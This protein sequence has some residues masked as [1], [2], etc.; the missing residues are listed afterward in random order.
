MPTQSDPAA[1]IVT[2]ARPWPSAWV[3]AA[4]E[5]AILGALTAGPLHGY[6]IAQT[7]AARGFGTLRGGSLYPVLARLEEA[8][9]VS[10][11]WVEGQGGPG[12]KD[13][14][15]TD[16]GRAEYADAV[17]SFQALGAALA[18]LGAEG[19]AGPDDGC[20][21]ASVTAPVPQEVAR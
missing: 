20:T 3:R 2:A 16:A 18:A 19:E 21:A 12:R 4:L 13:Y 7:L 5:L 11:R 10:T 17:A 6:G 14:A 15:L 9:H 1:P 8:G